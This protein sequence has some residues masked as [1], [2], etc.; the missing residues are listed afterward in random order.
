[1]E[2]HHAQLITPRNMAPETQST[3]V[4]HF[5]HEETIV[6]K[7][8]MGV[9]VYRNANEQNP[10]ILQEV[11]QQGG[12]IQR[13][14]DME[15]EIGVTHTE[16]EGDYEVMR[17]GGVMDLHLMSRPEMKCGISQQA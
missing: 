17:D 1:M 16:L 12:N 7:K 6:M 15:D 2:A 14:D 11:N 10:R 3:K 9:K 13:V 4:T 5:P 8:H